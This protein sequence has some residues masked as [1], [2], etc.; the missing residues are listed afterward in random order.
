[1]KSIYT[2]TNL[3]T[4]KIYVGKTSNTKNRW[5]HHL[6]HLTK[7][8]HHCISLQKDYNNLDDKTQLIF[9]VIFQNICTRK[10]EIEL[11]NHIGRDL[12]YNTKLQGV[13]K[14]KSSLNNYHLQNAK[15]IEGIMKIY[16]K[17]KVLH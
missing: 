6:S 7:G 15:I 17:C 3:C 16:S 11:M 4:Q 9:D 1:V 2:I 8:T 13:K 5:S 12:L 10:K 14:T